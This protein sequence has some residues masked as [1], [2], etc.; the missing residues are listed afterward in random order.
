MKIIAFIAFI[1]E[2]E[3][4]REIFTHVGE[5]DDPPRI[6]PARDPP[7]WEAAGQGGDADALLAQPMP[8]YEFDQRVSW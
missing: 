1:D 7:L 3:A 5:P 8:E 2:G 4:I 6:A